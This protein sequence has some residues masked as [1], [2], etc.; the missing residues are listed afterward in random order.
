MLDDYQS[1][2]DLLDA[3]SK[4]FVDRYATSSQLVSAPAL[5]E[6]LCIARIGK[7]ST[8]SIERAH[9]SSKRK[10]RMQ[11]DAGKAMRLT[12]MSAMRVIRKV[13]EGTFLV[14]SVLGVAKQNKRHQTD[15]SLKKSRAGGH[16][17]KARGSSGL[18]KKKTKQQRRL[19]RMHVWMA[20]NVSGRKANS[21]D[22]TRYKQQMAV[23]EVRQHYEAAKQ[24]VGMGSRRKRQRVR[25]L[26]WQVRLARKAAQRQG[27][28]WK[29]Q[30]ALADIKRH[31][32]AIGHHHFSLQKGWESRR[33]AK[34]AEQEQIVAQ[35]QSSATSCSLDFLSPKVR[36]RICTWEISPPASALQKCAEKA[37]FFQHLWQ[38][39]I[40]QRHMHG[41][42]EDI[43]SLWEHDHVV[44]QQGK[45]GVPK[46]TKAE[47]AARTIQLEGMPP[48]AARYNIST[49]IV[50]RILMYA[51]KS[52]AAAPSPGR[53]HINGNRIILEATRNA[54]ADRR[55]F[56]LIFFAWNRPTRLVC[57]ELAA[58]H[59][60]EDKQG[61][62]VSPIFLPP[63]GDQKRRLRMFNL[64]E[65]G[66][67]LLPHTDWSFSLW[68]V[69]AC[70]PAAEASGGAEREPAILHVNKPQAAVAMSDLAENAEEFLEDS[71]ETSGGEQLEYEKF[72]RQTLLDNADVEKARNTGD[73][74]VLD[75][76]R[77]HAS[78]AAGGK[79]LPTQ[80]PKQ[81]PV[82]HVD[83]STLNALVQRV[84]RAPKGEQTQLTDPGNS[85]SL[86]WSFLLYVGWNLNNNQMQCLHVFDP[87]KDSIRTIFTYRK[88]VPS[89]PTG[90]FQCR[91]YYHEAAACP[92][93][94]VNKFLYVILCIYLDISSTSRTR[95]L[96]ADS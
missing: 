8:N 14:Q 69:A 42:D 48:D 27:S 25:V 87:C 49:V 44:I 11:C 19:S 51:G 74:Q 24:F 61:A 84:K 93:K 2:P 80:P 28:E 71:D 40:G 34:K 29:P 77:V 20:G 4:S 32:L 30:E 17:H 22:F 73:A 45:A 31:R 12:E 81:A 21:D 78:D 76:Q 75:A 43:L 55:F 58:I 5:A 46:E 92:R 3:V 26:G 63:H 59:F 96:L 86:F 79:A 72:Q 23:P 95:R 10:A 7:E 57:S 33:K 90:P 50:N 82:Q 36:Q 38:P 18:G 13:L 15:S 35:W 70:R 89:C 68:H 60:S 85:L 67:Q 53:Q 39:D 94:L 62:W 1:S 54:G 37:R 41:S 64:P 65:L 88:P 16:P 91:C 6:L 9:S 56:H 83:N 47:K 52:T 66:V